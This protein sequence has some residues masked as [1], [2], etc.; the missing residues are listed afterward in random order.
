M[1]LFIGIAPDKGARDALAQT[2]RLLRACVPGRYADPSLYHLTIAFLGEV[3]APAMAAIESAMRQAAQ[4]IPPF[5]VTLGPVGTFGPVFWRGACENAAL[6]T[7]ASGVR[8][9]LDAAGIRY[10]AKPFRAHFTLA[11]DIRSQPRASLP[12]LPEASFTADRLILYE[13]TRV[14]GR[15]AYIPRAEVLL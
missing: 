11:R 3:S 12:A 13:S 5:S 14:H 6:R 8:A 10:D 7:A 4:G 2:A 1:R 9:A 15:L